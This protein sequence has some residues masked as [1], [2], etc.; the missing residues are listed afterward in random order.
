MF[1]F[2]NDHFYS[3]K[4]RNLLKIRKPI[5]LRLSV[6]LPIGFRYYMKYRNLICLQLSRDQLRMSLDRYLSMGVLI[7]LQSLIMDLS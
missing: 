7:K 3:T 2:S 1:H 4:I 6:I 5:S